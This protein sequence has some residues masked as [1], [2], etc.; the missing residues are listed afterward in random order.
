MRKRWHGFAALGL[1]VIMLGGGAAGVSAWSGS[2]STAPAQ[3]SYV[4]AA[5]HG[6]SSL[7]RMVGIGD[8]GEAVAPGTIDD[9]KNLLPQAGISLDQAIQAAQSA[10]SGPIGEVDLEHFDGRL[11]FNVD[12][13]AHDVKVDAATGNVL[14]ANGTD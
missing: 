14:S 1:G 12:V 8:D 3:T 11:V 5:S 9:G 10:A 4:G 6:V 2:T 7:A 13:G